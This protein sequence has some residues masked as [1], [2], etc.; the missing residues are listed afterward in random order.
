SPINSLFNHEEDEIVS[1]KVYIVGA[2]PGDIGLMTIKGLDCISTSDVI[3]YDFHINAQL[4]N[5]ARD[6][7]ELI[8]AGKRG[9]YH[10]MTQEEIN[11]VLIEKAKEG[12]SV[13]RLKGGDPF[14]F[15]RGGEEVESLKE[16]GIEYEV[17]P[18]I[19]SAIAAPAYAGIPLTHRLYSSSLA[20]IT[21]CEANSK[22]GSSIN[23]DKISTG[24][25]TLVFLMAMRNISCV[26]EN[27]ISHGRDPM[28]PVAVI[29]WGTRAEQESIVGNLSNIVD[30]IKMKEIRPPCVVVVGDVVN[31]REK[32]KWFENKPLFGHRILLTRRYNPVFNKLSKLGA[33]LIEMPTIEIVPP[34][35]YDELDEAINRLSSYDYIVFTSSNA[36]KYFFERLM[37]LGRDLR[38][39]KGIEICC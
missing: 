24:V 9:G 16:A 36:V 33:E 4:L 1:G 10:A 29:R 32:L 15:G 8:Y 12:K 23:W 13:C 3:V 11:N 28:T 21:G 22:K 37:A 6:D 26:T 19:S 17:V 39:L 27:L 30:M 31:L 5:Y 35:S 14:V 38:D 18:G 7:A 2:G 34:S 20:I 25:D